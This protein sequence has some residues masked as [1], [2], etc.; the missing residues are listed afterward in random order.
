MS[1]PEKPTNEGLQAAIRKRRERRE[2]WQREGEPTIGQSLGMI[3]A[4]GWAIVVPTLLGVLAGHWLD[5]RMQSGIFYTACF[6]VIG[7]VI[8]CVLAWQRIQKR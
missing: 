3:G 6:L 2:R 1:T 5:K 8:G 4:L 7:L